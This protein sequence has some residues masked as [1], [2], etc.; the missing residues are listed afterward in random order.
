[1]GFEQTKMAL[2]VQGTSMALQQ[3]MVV[4]QQAEDAADA[5]KA[6]LLKPTEQPTYTPYPTYTL[7]PTSTPEPVKTDIPAVPTEQPTQDIQARIKSANILVFEDIRSYYDLVPWVNRALGGMDF[8][9]GKIIEVGDAVGTFMTHLNSPTKWDLII[10]AAESKKGVR[11]E[12]WDIIM[13]HVK[14]DVALVAEVWYLDET[15]NGRIAPLLS[16]CGI[17]FQRDWTSDEPN[18]LGRSLY[19]LDS[20]H[21][22]FSNPNV[23]PPLFTSVPW[24]VGDIGDQIRLGAGGDAQLLAGR[25]LREKSQY[26]TLATCLEGRVIFQTFS[27][28]D[29]RQSQMIPLWQNYITYTL[30]NRFKKVP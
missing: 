28:H 17:E 6:E 13:D 12:F 11:G 29:Y 26:G 9:G 18:P 19:W 5:E 1:N 16:K 27:T 4:V 24:W 2:D 7:A 15:A 3:T 10:V 20:G 25:I 23:V 22:L 21:E 30:T 8:S 14:K